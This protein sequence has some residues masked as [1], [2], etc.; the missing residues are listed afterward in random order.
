[1]IILHIKIS[2]SYFMFIK[3]SYYFSVL[4]SITFLSSCVTKTNN[5]AWVVSDHYLASEVGVKIIQAGGNAIDA[6][7]ATAF[8]LAVTHPQAGN[9]GGGG[10]LVLRNSDGFATTIDFRETAPL[11]A[12]PT[13]FLNSEGKLIKGANHS[14]LKSVGV[15]G[16]VA[17]LYLAHNKYGLLPWESLLQ[18]A[19]DLAEKGFPLSQA[20]VDWGKVI[21]KWPEDK[22]FVKGFFKDAGGQFL[23]VNETW[24]Q[25]QQFPVKVGGCSSWTLIYHNRYTR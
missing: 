16:T 11:A 6:S 21:S 9:I 7:V 4:F 8:A 23:S 25:P 22:I 18:P 19:I 2:K 3:T 24:K 15:P 20:L 12:S 1:V 5:L 17:G 13:M 10:F 14:G